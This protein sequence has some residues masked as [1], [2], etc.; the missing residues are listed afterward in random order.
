MRCQ[1]SKTLRNLEQVRSGSKRFERQRGQRARSTR[2]R[3]GTGAGVIG[4]HAQRSNDLAS[5]LTPLEMIESTL[6]DWSIGRAMH[7]HARNGDGHG[8]LRHISGGQSPGGNASTW[9]GWGVPRLLRWPT[10]LL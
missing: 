2:R 7:R 5:S 4:T 3:E 1:K 6:G 9:D 8:L 10:S